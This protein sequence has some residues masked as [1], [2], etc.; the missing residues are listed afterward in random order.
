MVNFV[1]SVL[2]LVGLGLFIVT[3]MRAIRRPVGGA[4]RAVI[5]GLGALVS[6]VFT[7]LC[8][9]V[10][11]PQVVANGKLQMLLRFSALAAGVL[12]LLFVLALLLPGALGWLEKRGFVFFVGT[13]HVRATKSGFL[14]VISVLSMSGVGVSSC[15]LCSTTSI[16]GG[17]GADLKRKILA[18]NP[19]IIV[20]ARDGKGI[21]GWQAETLRLQAQL[22]DVGGIVNATVVGDAMGASDSNTTGVI[23]RG[24]TTDDFAAAA[25]AR[26][27]DVGRVEFFLAPEM[28]TKLSPD[29]VV[30]LGPRGEKFL[31]GPDLFGLDIPA[32]EP[33]SR[34]AVLPPIVLG[35]EVAKNLHVQLGDELSLLSPMGELGPMGLLPKT[36][37][38]RVAG[39][40][41]TG[42]YEFDASHAYIPL[43]AA[44]E[45]LALGGTV[46]RLEVR[47]PDPEAIASARSVVDAFAASA[48]APTVV[49]DWTEL[50]RSLFSALKLERIAQFII[51][52]IAIVVASFCIV[53]TLLLMVTEKGKEIAILK[54]LGASDRSIMRIFMVEGIVIGAIGTTFGVVSAL[55]A[56]TGLERLGVKIDPDIYYI[57]RL[58]VDVSASNYALVALASLG[59]CALATLYP[60]RAAAKL[61]PVD[62][63]RYE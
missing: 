35:R 22:K 40:F 1:A 32:G 57:D 48:R 15:A 54:A 9:A 14:T 53:C 17:F 58:P 25:V 42:M 2:A 8:V 5:W 50:N 41:F 3:L 46:R 20:E 7:G 28:L 6:L 44:Q 10:Q 34:G 23:V 60:A 19:H 47:L 27:L 62:G 55:V 18:Y 11:L 38:L 30:S 21:E 13:R 33:P 51:L 26:S 29:E 59:I 16:M 12:A 4:G 39:I 45:L 24:V 61:P 37:K 63:L 31:K 36:M 52:S 49:R 56:A 43:A